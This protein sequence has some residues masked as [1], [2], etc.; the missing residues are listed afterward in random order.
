MTLLIARN[1]AAQ[2]IFPPITRFFYECQEKETH[3]LDQKLAITLLASS[4]QLTGW[5]K[6]FKRKRIGRDCLNRALFLH[7]NAFELEWAG[8]FPR[9]DFFWQ[10]LDAELTR[11]FKNDATWRSLAES[12]A[13]EQPGLEVLSDP[14]N[15]RARFIEELLIDTH[16]A[17]F[18]GYAT[19]TEQL[20]LESRA[21][22]HL[23]YLSSALEWSALTADDKFRL[24]RTAT[25]AEIKLLQEANRW[26]EVSAR[27]QLLIRY[28]PDSLDFEELLW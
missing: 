13:S 27:C 25:E 10:E 19:K 24:I 28:C 15:I 7:R 11:L 26:K 21:W 3:T 16:A 8:N 4:A 5:D 9:A 14:A 23:G 2:R 6:Y 20:T 18:N 12:L 1:V 17:F 22:K